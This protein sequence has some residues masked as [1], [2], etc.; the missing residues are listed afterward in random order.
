MSIL[1][2][3]CISDHINAAFVSMKDLFHKYLKKIWLQT[4]E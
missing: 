2:F 4:F 3:R 1:L